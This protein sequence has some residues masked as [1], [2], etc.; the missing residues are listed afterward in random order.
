MCV[1]VCVCVCVY[2]LDEEEGD[3][4]IQ[5]VALK[6][7]NI[8]DN[9]TKLFDLTGLMMRG[10]GQM[11]DC[12]VYLLCV[13]RLPTTGQHDIYRG[14]LRDFNTLRRSLVFS[15]DSLAILGVGW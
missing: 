2:S 10:G 9:F 14:P 15:E 13:L 1:C 12:C 6:L 8:T 11:H 7:S 5:A 3:K 4:L